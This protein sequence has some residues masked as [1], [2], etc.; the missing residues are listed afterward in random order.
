MRNGLYIITKP[1]KASTDEVLKNER[2]R[3]CGD[4]SWE[5]LVYLI[6]IMFYIYYKRF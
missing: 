5:S 3:G 2:N 1:Y 6:E 4:A